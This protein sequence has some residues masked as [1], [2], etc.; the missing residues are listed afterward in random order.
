MLLNKKKPTKESASVNN[1]RIK[2]KFNRIVIDSLERKMGFEL[3]FFE[4]L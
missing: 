4:I 3:R 2:T 1:F